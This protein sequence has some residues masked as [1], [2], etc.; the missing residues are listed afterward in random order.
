MYSEE[1]AKVIGTYK[2]DAN[3][4]IKIE[5][6]RTG[7]YKIIEK[8][9]NKWYDLAENIEIN[10]E[11][12]KEASI[13]IEN[14]LKKGQVKVIKLDKD[15]GKIRI[16]N[17]KFNVIDEKGN[18][19]ETISTDENGEAYTS[20]YPI[21]DYEKIILKEI[22]TNENYTLNDIP[23]TVI[24][25][26]GEI[27]TIE[28]ENEVKKGQIKVIKFDKDNKE[29]KLEGVKFEIY[30]EDDNLIQILITDK[31][32]EAI[33]DK[34]RISKK[35][36]IKEVETKENYILNENV[37]KVVLEENEIKELIYENEK[38]KVKFK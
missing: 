20:R 4:E 26:E 11:W 24:L 31:N 14:E 35:Y 1:F 12:N 13:I 27:T 36:Y 33:T 10:I 7:K 6:L 9:T 38:R 15:D 34:L 18:I 30:D 19:L 28:I 37:T 25:K 16:P 17:V 21:R 3:G 2:T 5:N 32:G 23:Q 8:N 29:I 22:K